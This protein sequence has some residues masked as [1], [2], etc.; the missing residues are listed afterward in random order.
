MSF[1]F[2]FRGLRWGDL[3]QSAEL[4]RDVASLFGGS[5]PTF[6]MRQDRCPQSSAHAWL[7]WGGSGGAEEAWQREARGPPGAELRH[8]GSVAAGAQ[9]E[10]RWGTQLKV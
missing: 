6:I 10:P 9:A 1:G 8:S 5:P 4:G 7:T 3:Q 2:Y